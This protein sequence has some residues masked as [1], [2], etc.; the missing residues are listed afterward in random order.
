MPEVNSLEIC[1]DN[2]K[3]EAEF[4]NAITTAVFLLLE[5]NYIMTIKYDDPGSGIVWIQ[6]DF[7]DESMG[8]AQPLWL[9][10][11][12]WERLYAERNDDES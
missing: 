5:A 2:Y 11:D 1:R 7:A 3:T 4:K 9:T 8:G 12:E 6:Y 10:Y